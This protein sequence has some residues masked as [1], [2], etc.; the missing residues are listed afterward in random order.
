[1]KEIQ[2]RL[3]SLAD[4]KYAEFQA[5][6]IPTVAPEKF[7]GVRVPVLRRFS[8]EF[9]KDPMCCGFMNTLP[10]EYFDENL[11]HAILLGRIKDYDKCVA[12]VEVFLPCID[13]WAMCDTLSPKVFGKHKSELI[14][15]IKEWVASEKTYTCRFGI[16]MLMTHYLDEDFKAEYL[17]IP[18]SVAGEEYYVRMM[19]AWYYATALAKQ[20]DAAIPYI[21]EHRLPKWTHNKT[22][23]K[24]CESYRITDEQK[25]YLKTLR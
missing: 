5:K 9:E 25:A 8:K 12:A 15:K 13:N 18:E 4:S 10:H 20:W 19:V 24:A 14:E 23:Q 1:M 16:N 17:E 6:L 21:E 22:I 7:I 11:L 3:F 2:K